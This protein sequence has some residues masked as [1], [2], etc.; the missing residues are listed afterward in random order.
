MSFI[1]R[2]SFF[3]SRTF[4][5]IIYGKVRAT[6]RCHVMC[7]K[8]IRL[9]V[10]GNVCSGASFLLRDILTSLKS[11]GAIFF[12]LEGSPFK[13]KDL[14]LFSPDEK[15][16]D[17]PTP[18]Y[19]CRQ[20]NI[21][22]SKVMHVGPKRATYELEFLS[23]PGEIFAL[24]SDGHSRYEVYALLCNALRKAAR[25]F[26]ANL[27]KSQEGDLVW[28]VEPAWG[29][30]GA[31]GDRIGQSFTNPR[32]QDF[33]YRTWEQIFAELKKNG[34]LPVRGSSRKISGKEFLA[35][36][37]E[38]DTDSAIRSIQEW[39]RFRAPFGLGIGATDFESGSHDRAFVFYH[40]CSMATDI[41]V[42]DRIYS[43]SQP[44]DE[45]PFSDLI[46]ILDNIT[47]YLDYKSQP[48]F[49]LAF[50]NVDFMMLSRESSYKMLYEKM[51][52][53]LAP[54]QCSNAIYSLFCYAILHHLDPQFRVS[55]DH[56]HQFI[57]VPSEMVERF[58]VPTAI[59]DDT[60]I[61][62]IDL[63]TEA[64]VDLEPEEGVLRPEAFDLRSYIKSRLGDSGHAFHM[65]LRKNGQM[66]Q[67]RYVEMKIVP[68]VYFT[69][70]PI[71]KGYDIY[72]NAT[73]NG[74]GKDANDFEKVID[75][76]TCLF[77][78]QSS[79]ACFGSYQ[80]T[81]DILAQHRLFNFSVGSLLRILQGRL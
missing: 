15:G 41:V 81:M 12:P 54:M 51:L 59:S 69:S 35:H 68:H 64:I 37:F 60:F 31:G 14:M 72:R 28:I 39:I 33:S 70:T 18:L 17:G 63:L 49:Y 58:S 20:G 6:F 44:N 45:L 67:D 25:P 65:L 48:H 55:A 5:R 62:D 32:Y 78:H 38:Y 1:D 52:S 22:G 3:F 13:C 56:L 10:V 42:C 34:Y 53:D 4:L 8:H 77:S 24:R 66:D 7:K 71:T 50:R 2:L 47:N 75:G 80:L 76:N 73:G 21:Y 74:S 57:G 46:S 19:A 79:S 26:T 11:M 40:Y 23:I 9:A 30:M 36:F 29:W 27:W 16:G 43:N 61:S